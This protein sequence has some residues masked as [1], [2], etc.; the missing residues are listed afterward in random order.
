MNAAIAGEAAPQP[1]AAEAVPPV[2]KAANT[3]GKLI[4]PV[5]RGLYVLEAFTAEHQWLGNGDIALSTGIPRASVSRILQSLTSLGYLQHDPCARKYALAPRVLSLGYA[6]IAQSEVRFAARAPMQTLADD[7][8]AYLTLGIRDRLDLFVLEACRGRGFDMAIDFRAGE[9]FPFSS[10]VSGWAMLGALPELERFYLL[11]NI[12]RKH[13][14]EWS[15]LRRRMGEA[16]A[17]IAD[18]GFCS[19]PCEWESELHIVAVP[20]LL[21]GSAPLALACISRAR[22]MSKVRID[23]EIGPRMASLA[24][25]L[26]N[27]YATN[28]P[29]GI[30]G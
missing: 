12:Q 28:T 15:R 6:A 22:R 9:R 3:S 11:E 30:V 5:A 19:A 14:R 10:S 1:K 13:P 2:K 26:Q 24:M 20:V 16:I 21:E 17:Q 23:R 8:D 25:H 7:A 29:S 18:N 4:V 27:V